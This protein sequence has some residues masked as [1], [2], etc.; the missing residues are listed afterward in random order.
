MT[1]DATIDTA[2]VRTEGAHMSWHV[3]EEH[4]VAYVCGGLDEPEA[5][6]V[7]AHVAECEACATRVSEALHRNTELA[8][9][10]G[11]VRANVLTQA[12]SEAYARARVGSRAVTSWTRT[13]RLLTAAP[14]LR[15]PWMAAATFAVAC[16][17]MLSL[18]SGGGHEP[19]LLLA[20]P[21][22]PLAGVATSYG[23]GMDPTYE[24]SLT[25]P[26]SG[27]RLLLLRTLTVLGVTIP[28]LLAATF[29]I[30][31]GGGVPAAVWLMPTLAL[32]LVTLALGSW[33]EHRFAAAIAA[34]GWVV[35]VLVPQF[36]R[37]TDVSYVFDPVTQLVWAA[38]AALALGLLVAR[39]DAYDRME[40]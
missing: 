4:L 11:R 35:A 14:A 22:L 1:S 33:I 16:A 36:L 29:V 27:L 15:L 10:I 20:A 3:P 32:V 24:L 40:N 38:V 12:G 21:L 18:V 8:A 28:L 30:P 25:T 34:A 5:W 17:A 9:R 13:W 19:L 39:R 23:P 7:E 2:R 26:H 6:S 37:I 31:G